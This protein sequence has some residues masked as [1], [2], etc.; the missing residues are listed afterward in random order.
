MEVARA[1]APPDRREEQQ[2]RRE[3]AADLPRG[4]LVE[5]RQKQAVH[6]GDCHHAGGEAPQRRA[7]R[8]GA[9][10]KQEYGDRAQPR[11]EGGSDPGGDQNEHAGPASIAS[12]AE[13]G[14]QRSFTSRS[15]LEFKIVDMNRDQPIRTATP[16]R[17]TTRPRRKRPPA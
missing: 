1:Q 6:R 12:E 10:G 7:Q 11:R 3:P 15:A 5:R 16:R 8:S 9:V 13:R 4:A 2:S 17:T 14:S